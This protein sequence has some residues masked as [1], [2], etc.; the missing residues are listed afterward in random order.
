[1]R[2]EQGTE[3][4]KCGDLGKWTEP[5][6]LPLTIKRIRLSGDSGLSLSK[7]TVA[8]QR[9]EP[10]PPGSQTSSLHHPAFCQHAVSFIRVRTLLVREWLS[11]YDH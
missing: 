8:N 4:R 1:M 9:L 10:R 11:A 6:H 2:G 5:L 7:V 3:Q